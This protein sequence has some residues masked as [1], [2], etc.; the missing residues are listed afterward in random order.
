MTTATGFDL[1]PPTKHSL[2]RTSH[3]NA[4]SSV[5]DDVVAGGVDE[6][7]ALDAPLVTVLAR[8]DLRLHVKLR[9][10]IC[11]TVT[12]LLGLGS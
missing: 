12:F 6:G 5:P 2:S 1:F 10:I 3:V 9:K 11:E 7:E 8:R 4:A